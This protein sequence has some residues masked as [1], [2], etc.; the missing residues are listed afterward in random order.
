MP[1]GIHTWW[2]RMAPRLDCG[3]TRLKLNQGAQTGAGAG[4]PRCSRGRRAEAKL[5]VHFSR[6]AITSARCSILISLMHCCPVSSCSMLAA[7]L[8]C[9]HTPGSSTCLRLD[10]QD[11]DPNISSRLRSSTRC[12]L[13]ILEFRTL[14]RCPINLSCASWITDQLGSDPADKTEE[15]TRAYHERY[16]MG[17]RHGRMLL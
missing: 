9:C 3:A 2:K 8:D 11:V 7:R 13:K 6:C 14:E 4:N 15:A 10:T 16:G 5:R 17:F 1:N 12:R